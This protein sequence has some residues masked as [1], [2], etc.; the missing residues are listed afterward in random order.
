VKS[1]R[2]FRHLLYGGPDVISGQIDVLPT[3]RG[4][5]GQQIIGNRGSLRLQLAD[6][7]VEIDRIPVNGGGG[8]EAQA[9]CAETLIFE[10]AVSNFALTMKEHRTPQRIAGLALVETGMTALAQLRIG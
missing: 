9:R 8:D 4:D 3:E 5:M 2:V 1:V 7:T 10:G 6:G